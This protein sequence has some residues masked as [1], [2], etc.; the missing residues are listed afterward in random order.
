MPLGK[1]IVLVF[2][3]EYLFDRNGMTSHQ[4]GTLEAKWS[5]FWSAYL[6]TQFSQRSPP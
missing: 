2:P 5:P 3:R 6:T 4:D 1:V